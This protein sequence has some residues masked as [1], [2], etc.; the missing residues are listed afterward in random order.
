MY[1]AVS[2]SIEVMHGAWFQ[3]KMLATVAIH[4]REWQKNFFYTEVIVKLAQLIDALVQN[5][6]LLCS[7]L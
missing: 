7:K 6:E 2:L 1:F 3:Q 4:H 5:E